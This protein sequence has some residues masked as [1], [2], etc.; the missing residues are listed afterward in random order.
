MGRVVQ[1]GANMTTFA[2]GQFVWCNS[3]S[4]GGQQGSFTQRKEIAR[5]YVTLSHEFLRRPPHH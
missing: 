4:Y 3:L 5:T 2:P 1:T